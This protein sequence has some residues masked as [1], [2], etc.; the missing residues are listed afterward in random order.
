MRLVHLATA[1]AVTAG[2]FTAAVPAEAHPLDVVVVSSLSGS[3]PTGYNEVARVDR[4]KV[5]L[6]LRIPEYKIITNG[7]PCNDP[8]DNNNYDEYSVLDHYRVC[9][10]TYHSS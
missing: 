6:H 5:C 7:A 8:W 9:V 1:A 2:A 4:Y 3:C 10:K